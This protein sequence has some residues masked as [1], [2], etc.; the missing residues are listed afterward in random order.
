MR[1]TGPSPTCS[2]SG[3][4]L[5]IVLTRD[6]WMHR[7]DITRATKAQQVLTAEHDGVL[8][9]DVVEEWATRHARPCTLT[10]TGPVGG[11]WS[12]GSGGPNIELD[13]VEFC[14]SCPAA[15]TATAC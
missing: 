4:L 15:A 7:V 9:A 1:E 14:P 6:P 12:A 10:L 11:Q 13:A 5:D 3:F 2:S 8:V